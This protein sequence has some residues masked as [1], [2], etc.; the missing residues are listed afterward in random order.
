MPRN[1]RPPNDGCVSCDQLAGIVQHPAQSIRYW[2]K[3]GMVNPQVKGAGQGNHGRYNLTD[4][5]AIRAIVEL[6]RGGVSLQAL[7]KV[8]ALIASRGESFGS[9]RLA[10]VRFNS[11]QDVVL[12]AG[13]LEQRQ[14]AESLLDKPG[15]TVLAQVALDKIAKETQ[16]QFAGVIALNGSRRVA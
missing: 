15:Q 13:K 12:L 14:F 2:V 8:H 6:R 7:R 10:A 9:C 16:R 5:T 4:V 1:Y 11:K 3:T